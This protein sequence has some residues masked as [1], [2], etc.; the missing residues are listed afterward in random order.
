VARESFESREICRVAQECLGVLVGLHEA[1]LHHGNLRP[2]NIL[3]SPAG[4][5]KVLDSTVLSGETAYSLSRTL[6][7]ADYLS[8]EEKESLAQK[9]DQPRGDPH[10]GDV[11]R[12]GLVLFEMLSLKSH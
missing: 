8:P 11:F 12:L 6:G 1:G 4:E 7:R 9:L 2:C 5:V 3:Y 10:K